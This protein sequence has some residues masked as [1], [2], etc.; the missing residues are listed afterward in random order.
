MNL[1]G[2][3]YVGAIPSQ[4]SPIVISYYIDA[5]D[6]QGNTQVL[7]AGADAAGGTPFSFF[8][9]TKTPIYATSFE[10]ANDNGWTHAQVATQDDWQRGAPTGLGGD[11]NAAYTGSKVWGNDLGG[12]GFNGFYG[13][14]VNNYLRS[15]MIDCS[16]ATNVSLEFRRWLGVESG[17]F[18]H[19]QIKVNNVIVWQNPSTG[20]TID[21]S[22]VPF[23]LDISSLA[24][25]NPSVQIEFRL[26]SDGGVT[27]GGWTI[28]DF[29]LVS[30]GPGSGNC[31]SPATYCTA[32][33]NSQ[34]C[35]PAIATN[36]QPSF[37]TPIAFNVTCSQVLNNKNGLLFYG[38]QASGAPFQGGHLC[39]KLP[40]TRTNVQNSGGSASGTDC[41]GTYSFDFNALI[42]SG[43]DPSLAQ[44]VDVFAQYWYR[45]PQDAF[46]TGLSDA[47]QFNIC[48]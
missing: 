30:L 3:S 36:G 33:V 44:G 21:T 40:I 41:T 34:L 25:G 31:P 11:P 14:N 47:V 12:P 8:V 43:G 38:S 35:V 42:Q 29:S 4:G 32:K 17:Q 13:N 27:F 46:S 23:A 28:D 39:V 2:G 1:S 16:S 24:A 9:G 15:P 48:P 6:D 19:A 22:W 10:E 45:D 18:D 5:S 20:D 7:P 37:S 26:I